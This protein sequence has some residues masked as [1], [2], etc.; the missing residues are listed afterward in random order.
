MMNN[1]EYWEKRKA[2]EMFAYM[3]EAEK[4]AS[5]LTK[6]YLAA[7]KEVQAEA[8]K[9][10]HKYQSRYGLSRK[11]AERLLSK[12]K[13]P[14]DIKR[15]LEALKDDPQNTD[16]VKDLESQAYG[17]RIGR[18]T[19]LYNQIDTVALAI[20]AAQQKRICS[21]LTQLAKKAYYNNIFDI[22][23]Y[24]GYGFN[25]KLLDQKNIEKVLS[26]KWFGENYSGRI[27]KDTESLAKAVKEEVLL[28]LL[29]GRPLKKAAEAI[30]N[31]FNSGYDKARRLIRT[32]SSFVTNQVQLLSYEN[33][34]IERYIYVAILDLKTSLICRS[35]DKK[36]FFVKDA[37]PGKN[38][39]PM[40]PWC[41][42]TTIAYIS[43]ELLQ[44]MQQLAI[45]PSTGKMILVPADMTYQ[46][47]YDKFVSEKE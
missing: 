9:I 25:F 40:H 7:S 26:T 46:E 32:E 16:L 36:V 4:A 11:E 43:K 21:F 10:F 28:N 47:W 1:Q 14:T 27:W 8:K 17:A 20:Y 29:T 19:G 39:P 41:R 5:E 12:V 15:I 34:G 45:D 13:D 2:Q 31:K 30:N 35:L 37:T 22:Q 6:T 23:Q 24:V 18:L 3:E 33:C 44:K 42:S 38:Y